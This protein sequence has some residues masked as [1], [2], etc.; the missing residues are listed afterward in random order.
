MEREIEEFETFLTNS[1]NTELNEVDI[2]I[3]TSNDEMSIRE[4]LQEDSNLKGISNNITTDYKDISTDY[5]Y[6]GND[7]NITNDYKDMD[8]TTD[9]T[10]RKVL[11]QRNISYDYTNM[12]FETHILD[13]DSVYTYNNNL[14]PKDIYAVDN[15]DA[16]TSNN[17]LGINLKMEVDLLDTDDNS[18]VKI[19]SIFTRNNFEVNKPFGYSKSRYGCE[20][21]LMSTRLYF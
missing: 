9:Y 20:G 17:L 15:S 18:D 8:I 7:W 6:V 1:D 5:T 12:D 4:L 19:N 13:L 16:K 3:I 10:D 2:S 21:M 11:D 14:T